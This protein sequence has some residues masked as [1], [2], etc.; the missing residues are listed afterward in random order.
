MKCLLVCSFLFTSFCFSQ[1]KEYSVTQIDSIVRLN[2]SYGTADGTTVLKNKHGKL[3]GS[4]GFSIEAYLN[5]FNQAY[6]DSL[7][8]L[9]KR[10]YNRQKDSELIKG[11]YIYHVNY[12]AGG[13][14]T[15][16]SEFYYRNKLLL[17]AKVNVTQ[18][19]K[20]GREETQEF[21]LTSD[22][23][24]EGKPIKNVLL[25]DVQSWIHEKNSIVLQFYNEH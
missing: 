15:I 24:N 18:K 3:I 17:F 19:N 11:S 7:T 12:K 10:K 14:Q 2:G 5:Y 25:F 9:E 20:S 16:V 21:E 23:I 13:F 22:Q 1:N 8:N 6:Y 4:G